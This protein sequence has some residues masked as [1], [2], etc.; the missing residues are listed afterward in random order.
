MQPESDKTRVDISVIVP[1]RNEERYIRR[2]LDSLL[3]QHYS[4][5]Y[6]V[7]VVDGLSEDATAE[8]VRKYAAQ[9]ERVRLLSNPARITPAA[10]NIGVRA[11]KGELI[12]TVGAHWYVPPDYL[13]QITKLFAEHA[14]DCLGGRIVRVVETD[15]GRAIELA[16]ATVLGGGLSP[17]NDPAQPEQ[18]VN[19]PNIAYIW[20]RSV[21]D[22]VGL[23]DERFVRNQDNEFNLRTLEAGLTTMYSPRV[24]FYYYAPDNF[25]KLFR[26]MFGY[27]SYMPMM[28]IKHRRLLTPAMAVPAASLLFWAMLMVLGVAKTV[29]LVIPLV[30]PAI[31]AFVI[32]VGAFIA[33]LRAKKLGYWPAICLTY[34]IV[35]VGLG[36]GYLRGISRLFNLPLAVGLWRTSRI[37]LQ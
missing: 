22:Q 26:Q 15:I 30:L 13:Q 4:G 1:A 24:V 34:L 3:S 21:F 25:H 14:I 17:R 6:E 33:G 29:P 27:A 11:A 35:H 20:R 12:L 16:R 32:I 9:D 18:I 5:C 2:C 31:Y 8:I 19:A 36:L 7:I 23:F 10:F 28:I 37:S